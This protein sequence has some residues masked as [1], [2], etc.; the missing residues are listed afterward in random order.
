MVL[1]MWICAKAPISGFHTR[2]MRIP[3][4][5]E[6]S[7]SP[8]WKGTQSHDMQL[9]FLASIHASYAESPGRKTGHGDQPP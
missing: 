2:I 4:K 7:Y 9:I 3:E 6:P 8:Y 5:R 1:L